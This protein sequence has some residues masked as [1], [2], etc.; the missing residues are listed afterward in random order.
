VL[1]SHLSL[2]SLCLI[3]FSGNLFKGTAS[4]ERLIA[5]ADWIMNWKKTGRNQYWPNLTYEVGT[6]WEF[7]AGNQKDHESASD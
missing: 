7:R 5:A 2:S 3:T 4:F 1:F 6:T